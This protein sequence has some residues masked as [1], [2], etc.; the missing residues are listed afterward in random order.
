MKQL[1]YIY[2]AKRAPFNQIMFSQNL[3]QIASNIIDGV[4]HFLLSSPQV[5]QKSEW[6]WER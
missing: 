6:V 1:I 2:K 4:A 5:S 3:E